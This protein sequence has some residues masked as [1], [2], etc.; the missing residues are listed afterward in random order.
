MPTIGTMKACRIVIVVAFVSFLKKWREE[1]VVNKCRV[2]ADVISFCA[3]YQTLISIT[4]TRSGKWM[5][6]VETITTDNSEC[7]ASHIASL[8]IKVDDDRLRRDHMTASDERLLM[9]GCKCKGFLIMQNAF[10]F[11]IVPNKEPLDVITLFA[12]GKTENSISGEAIVVAGGG[13]KAFS[14]PMKVES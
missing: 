14:R 12:L 5:G 9:T 4:N 3:I 1:T 11:N 6:S 7:N 13:G 2:D 8:Q 10:W